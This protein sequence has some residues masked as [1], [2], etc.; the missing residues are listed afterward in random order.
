MTYSFGRTAV[1]A[2]MVSFIFSMY[3]GF[4]GPG[5]GTFML[6]LYNTWAGIDIRTSNG[7][8]KVLNLSSN[9]TSAVI[10]ILNGRV[11]IPLGL[12]AAAFSVAGNVVG[13]RIFDKK[14]FAVVRPLMIC[15]LAATFIKVLMQVIG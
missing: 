11:L 8:T 4:Y 2:V 7:L 13:A 14:G 5:A 6:L 3:D 1:I 9:I 10:F 12:A 15:V